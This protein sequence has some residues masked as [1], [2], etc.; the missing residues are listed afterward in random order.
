M[1]AQTIT[2]DKIWQFSGDISET[3]AKFYGYIQ[4]FFPILIEKKIGIVK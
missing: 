1:L 2:S 4:G 3:F